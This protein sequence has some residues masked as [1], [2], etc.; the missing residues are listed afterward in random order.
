MAPEGFTLRTLQPPAAVDPL[1]ED[2]EFGK[3]QA[4]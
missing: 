2:H 4:G 3:R 1:P